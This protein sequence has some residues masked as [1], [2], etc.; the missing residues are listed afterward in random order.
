MLWPQWL[1]AL[2][3]IIEAFITPFKGA[4]LLEYTTKIFSIP[5]FPWPMV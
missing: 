2:I 4:V 1:G 5:H 3:F